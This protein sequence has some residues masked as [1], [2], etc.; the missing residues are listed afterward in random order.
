GSKTG[1]SLTEWKRRFTALATVKRWTWPTT[2]NKLRAFLTGSAA[3]IV[4]YHVLPP[5]PREAVTEIWS[6]LGKAYGLTPNQ[7][8]HK[9]R[10]VQFEVGTTHID[11][12]ASRIAEW[13]ELAWPFLSPRDRDCVAASIF[14]GALPK[15]AQVKHAYAQV[16]SHHPDGRVTMVESVEICRPLFED[17]HDDTVELGMIAQSSSSSHHSSHRSTPYGRSGGSSRRGFSSAGKGK[18]RGKGRPG[19]TSAANQ[20][21]SLLQSVLQG[22]NG[23]SA[24]V[25]TCYRC[26]ERGHKANV[27]PRTNR[28]SKVS[29]LVILEDVCDRLFLLDS[30]CSL[31]TFD[32]STATA[33][34][35]ASA[36]P[37]DH[38]FSNLQGIP[39]KPPVQLCAGQL[40]VLGV[41]LTRWGIAASFPSVSGLHLSGLLGLDFIRAQGGL[42]VSFIADGWPCYSFG[43]RSTPSL[44]SPSPPICF[45]SAPALP[46]SVGIQVCDGFDCSTTTASL[47]IGTVRGSHVITDVVETGDFILR[48]HSPLSGAT[49]AYW[50]V[51]WKWLDGVPSRHIMIPDYNV[52][53]KFAPRLVDQWQAALEEWITLGW[54][55]PTEISLLQATSPLVLVPQEHKVSTPVRPCIDLSWVNDRIRSLPNELRSGPVACPEHIR[56]WRAFPGNPEDLFL[57]DLKKAFLQIHICPQQTYWLG[58]RLRWKHPEGFRMLRLPFGLSISPKCLEVC[59]DRVLQPFRDRLDKYLDDIVLPRELLTHVRDL[60][61]SNGFPTKEPEPLLSSRVLGLQ[62]DPSGRWHRRGPVP[63]L[64]VFTRRGV[65]QWAGKYV[66]HHPVVGWPR[67]AFSALKRLACVR[68]D[69]SSAQW[70][71]PL[72]D[73]QLAACNSLQAA[74]FQSGDTATGAWKYCPSDPWLLFTDSSQHAYG[75]V[76]KIGPIVVEDSTHLRKPGD[77]RHIN[78]AELDAL[79]R[80]LQ[81]VEKYI[82]ALSWTTRLPLTICCDNSSAVSWVTRH[83]QKHWRAVGGLNATLVE[84]R[85]RVLRDTATALR[86]DITVRHVDSA[87]NIA[88]PLSRIPRYCIL[89]PVDLPASSTDCLPAFLGDQSTAPP[90]DAHGRLILTDKR[91]LTVLAQAL[92]HHE[93]SP[94]LHDRLRELVS[95]PALRAFCRDFVRSCPT[96]SLSKVTVS[97]AVDAG[98]ADRPELP[99]THSPWVGV[100]M[101][102]V[103]PYKEYELYVVTL[104][105]NFSGY[106]L[107]RVTKSMPTSQVASALLRTVFE[108][109]NT[110]P[111]TVY[112]DG[113]SQ[114]TSAEFLSTLN[115]MHASSVPSPVA[116]SW[117]N[118]K[119]ERV[120]RVLNERV[121][122]ASATDLS[123]G[124]FK[125]T[126]AKAT[127]MFNTATTRRTGR[128]PHSL[129]FSF[130]PWPYPEVDPVFRPPEESVDTI[131]DA[132][133]PDSAPPLPRLRSGRLPAVGEI[134]L[135][136][137]F[138]KQK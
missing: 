134:W 73:Y 22:D 63:S 51:E 6:A 108:C 65:H 21:V 85:L 121:R 55:E 32:A 88:D 74:L 59:L 123:F 101:D 130:P 48:Q 52:R 93:G 110:V 135:V 64:E 19:G 119:V 47:D 10:T 114:F 105:D 27:C 104:V 28:P 33:L 3:R 78:L 138:G 34:T 37:V 17:E 122:S 61:A 44:T 70:D 66:A 23:G 4:D 106:L 42:V 11:D 36:D 50:E 56:R 15:T 132:D 71:A 13:S 30:G 95:Y 80:G 118:G 29:S 46:V 115:W 133:Y 77:R 124:L 2:L 136:R 67:A 117:V 35:R 100:H 72:D 87:S 83:L 86:L 1:I 116:S 41:T 92:H 107:T 38:S 102:I 91:A 40:D 125:T 103:G 128:T 68:H 112:H 111:R 8:V 12:L 25:V 120:H 94:A 99:R 24:A 5:T 76:L 82:R 20:L 53:E 16:S 131:T 45:S 58:L 89:R 54:L 57:V 62:C 84:N 97:A 39:G 18:G 7:A 90:R 79:V 69:G 26:G 14:W 43:P 137:R 98:L 75:S 129:V 31:S 81:L 60:L 126:I 113:G 127:S 9:L 109:F 96:C 49:P